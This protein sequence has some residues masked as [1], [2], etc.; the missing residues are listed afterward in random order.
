MR[1]F[2]E[3]EPAPNA[4]LDPYRKSA[5]R[6]YDGDFLVAHLTVRVQVWWTTEGPWWR[7]RNVRPQERVEWL[8]DFQ[9]DFDLGHPDGLDDRID[10]GVADLDAGR[11]TCRGWSLRVEWLEG[12]EAAARLALNDWA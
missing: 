3:P 5:A 1:T 8:L 11:F 6:L 9:P 7:R 12:H 10:A 2:W 4:R